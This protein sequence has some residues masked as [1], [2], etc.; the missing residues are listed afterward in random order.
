MYCPKCK[1]FLIKID[2]K[3]ILTFSGDLVIAKGFSFS[4][5]RVS[6]NDTGC[7]NI[8]CNNCNKELNIS[9]CMITCGECGN[10]INIK[11]AKYHYNY[12]CEQ[13][14]IKYEIKG[15]LSYSDFNDE[16]MPFLL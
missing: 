15:A 5:I 9:D 13:C 6:V 11:E 14:C 1:E 3:N 7:N 4:L 8:T 16:V 10:L 12:M 2:L